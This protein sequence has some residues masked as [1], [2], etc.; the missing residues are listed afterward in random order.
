[1]TVSLPIFILLS[2]L[3]NTV[4]RHI[5]YII[6]LFKLKEKPYL[7][8]EKFNRQADPAEQGLPPLFIGLLDPQPTPGTG[9]W[10]RASACRY[11]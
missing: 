8:C 10:V 4:F 2:Q 6:N 3:A 11:E 1:V 9:P 5:Y 7:S